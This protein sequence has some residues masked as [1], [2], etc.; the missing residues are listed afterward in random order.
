MTFGL[1]DQQDFAAL[2]QEFGKEYTFTHVEPGT[3]DPA[4]GTTTGDVTTTFNAYA[5][6]DNFTIADR[7][8]SDIQQD[9]VKLIAEW[10]SYAVDDTVSIDGESYRIINSMKVIPGDTGQIYELQVRK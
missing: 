9:D 3:Y 10:A 7:T 2:I 5:V 8:D 1:A 4:T 6:R